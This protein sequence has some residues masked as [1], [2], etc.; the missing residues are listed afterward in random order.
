MVN[1]FDPVN[2]TESEVDDEVKDIIGMYEDTESMMQLLISI[3]A[4]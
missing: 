3:R 2:W 1:L 4:V